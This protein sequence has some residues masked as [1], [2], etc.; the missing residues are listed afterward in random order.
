[1]NA[2]HM[3][4]SVSGSYRLVVRRSD[5][6]IKQRTGWCPNIITLAGFYYLLAGYSTSTGQT[7][8]RAVAGAGSSTP[9][10]TDTRLANYLGPVGSLIDYQSTSDSNYTTA[11]FYIE[12][13]WTFRS[14]QGGVVGN[15]SEIGITRGTSPSGS[16][17]VLSRALVVDA[18][19]S[20]TTVTVTSDEYLEVIWRLRYY[21]SPGAGSVVFTIDG[22]D[23]VFNYEYSPAGMDQITSNHGWNRPSNGA[24][25]TSPGTWRGAFSAGPGQSLTAYPYVTYSQKSLPAPNDHISGW[26][27]G[28]GTIP[29][30]KSANVSMGDKHVDISFAAGLGSW[31]GGSNGVWGFIQDWSMAK[32]AVVFDRP[33]PK[34]ETRVFRWTSRLTLGNT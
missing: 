4:A 11:P 9:Q 27:D 21:A 15:V 34:D 16:L 5:G 26:T 2:G 6:S 23:E 24:S 33:I 19:G 1:M 29:G 17:D 8:I 18:N 31:N 13:S 22:V 7:S 10:E 20:P 28:G 30:T 12:Q 32:F 25:G 14:N 3:K